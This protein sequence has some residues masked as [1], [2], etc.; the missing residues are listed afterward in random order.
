M[1]PLSPVVMTPN[2]DVA[3]N[4]LLGISCPDKGIKLDF[5]EFMIKPRRVNRLVAAFICDNRI[6]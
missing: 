3:E 4:M 1:L 6:S 5:L 2:S